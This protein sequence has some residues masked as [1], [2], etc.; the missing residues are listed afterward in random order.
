MQHAMRIPVRHLLYGSVNLGAMVYETVNLAVNFLFLLNQF[1]H[2]VSQPRRAL[3][4]LAGIPLRITVV[5]SAMLRR[6]ATSSNIS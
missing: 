1:P 6:T 3:R 2:G 4:F 5:F